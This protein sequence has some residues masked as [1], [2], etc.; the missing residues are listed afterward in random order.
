MKIVAY[1]S[2]IFILVISIFQNQF[3]RTSVSNSMSD[4]NNSL[5]VTIQ[6]SETIESGQFFEIAVEIANVSNLPVIVNKRLSVGYRESLSRELFVSIFTADSDNEVGI[7]KALY[8]R[9]F[10]TREDYI[11]VKPGKKL[12][13]KFNLFDWYEF[14]KPGKYNILV[15]YQADEDLAM[16]PN[17]VVKGVFCSEK[18]TIN[19]RPV[20]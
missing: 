13:A 7:Q 18:K 11:H 4:K 2:F 16:K 10:S 17:G 6:L 15:C 8:E 9:P 19:F 12:T 5:K 14:P 1:T 20:D 3:F